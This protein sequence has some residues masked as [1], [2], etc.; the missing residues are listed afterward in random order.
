MGRVVKILEYIKGAINKA[1]VDLSFR[2]ETTLDVV[3]PAG[4]ESSPLPLDKGF[5]VETRREGKYAIV[6][7]LSIQ[8]SVEPGGLRLFSRTPNGAQSAVVLLKNDGTIT[9]NGCVIKADG[10]VIT[11]DGVS[12]NNHT[13][14]VDVPDTPFSGFTGEPQ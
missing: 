10:D 4:I 13:H 3:N 9:A 7:V 8:G 11:P 14:S 5:A 1:R 2:N 6:G 12:L